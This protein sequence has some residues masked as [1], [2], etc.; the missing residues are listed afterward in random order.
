MRAAGYSGRGHRPEYP[1][2]ARAL[3]ANPD[4][5]ITQIAHRFGVSP[6]TL[7]RYTP[8]PNHESSGY[9]CSIIRTKS[10][11]DPPRALPED[12]PMSSTTVK[13][14]MAWVPDGG[15][16]MGSDH[17]YPEEGLV[18]D[19][20]VASFWIDK[21]TVTNRDFAAF[22]AATG[23]KTVAER[24]PNPAHYPGADPRLLKA[25]SLVFYKTK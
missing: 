10:S 6:A 2:V 25:G 23:Y 19:V 8:R 16:R 24:Q 13:P 9:C 4:I 5:G 3:L 22:I 14:G 20:I 11:I 1:E 21:H 17:H 15:F 7:Y 12:R 18:H